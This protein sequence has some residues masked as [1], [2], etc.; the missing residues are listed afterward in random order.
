MT[1]A[2]FS[3]F[4]WNYYFLIVCEVFSGNSYFESTA[5]ALVSWFLNQILIA[6]SCQSQ[7]IRKSHVSGRINKLN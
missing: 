7:I 6:H 2:L 1:T 4:N 5:V 3:I